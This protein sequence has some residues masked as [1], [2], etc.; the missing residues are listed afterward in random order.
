MNLKACIID[1]SMFESINPSLG[2]RD[3]LIDI[4]V[5]NQTVNMVQP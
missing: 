1:K 2:Y 3:S 4:Y 5:L